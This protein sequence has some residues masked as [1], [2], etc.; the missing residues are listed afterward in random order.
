[1]NIHICIY[2]YIYGYRYIY[3]YLFIFVYIH[4]HAFNVCMR[5]LLDSF[6]CF[7]LKHKHTHASTRSLARTYTLTNV[8]T[9][10]ILNVCGSTFAYIYLYMKMH[11]PVFIH[12]YRY[13]LLWKIV[14][15]N[16]APVGRCAEPPHVFKALLTECRALL[17]I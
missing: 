6:L 14:L 9:H 13:T 3:I 11:I 8:Q 17:M 1:M 5:V 16:F 2:M 10:H 15:V 7:L 12:I 4:I